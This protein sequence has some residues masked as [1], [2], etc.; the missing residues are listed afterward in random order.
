[1]KD[2]KFVG[3][4]MRCCVSVFALLLGTC[5]ASLSCPDPDMF[6]QYCN[7]TLA[8][9]FYLGCPQS[10]VYECPTGTLCVQAFERVIRCASAGVCTPGTSTDSLMRRVLQIPDE[11]CQGNGSLCDLK[12]PCCKGL[13][14]EP[15]INSAVPHR[16][17][18][19]VVEPRRHAAPSVGVVLKPCNASDTTQLFEYTEMAFLQHA[20]SGLTLVALGD[21]NSSSTVA[22]QS[23]AQR[24][25]AQWMF[26]PDTKRLHA[27]RDSPR[28]LSCTPHCDGAQ[29]VSCQGGAQPELQQFPTFFPDLD[30]HSRK[31][32]L[33]RTGCRDS[34]ADASHSSPLCLAAQ[35]SPGTAAS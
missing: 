32:G 15:P 2:R 3:I 22:L 26:H 10:K 1:M 8:S 23:V 30:P 6:G 17:E 13:K 12:L 28:C 18:V 11:P 5:N 19:E 27:F 33:V 24:L 20:A 9:P 29:V 14:C 21:Q 4:I 34:Q 35:G 7:D 16:D 25:S 31:H